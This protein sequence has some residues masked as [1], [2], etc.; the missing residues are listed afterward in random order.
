MAAWKSP[1]PRLVVEAPGGDRGPGG[2]T[3]HLALVPSAL[4]YDA[5]ANPDF[6]DFPG[7]VKLQGPL[8]GTFLPGLTHSLRRPSAA[9]CVEG[10]FQVLGKAA[11]V[12]RLCPLG[13]NAVTAGEP[14]SK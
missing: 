4:I 11:A 3:A 10:L 13:A 12:T 14:G 8:P 1:G 6:P 5:A 2:S 9:L 7:D